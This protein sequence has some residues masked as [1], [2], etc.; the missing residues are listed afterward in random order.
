M[1][2]DCRL[3]SRFLMLGVLAVFVFGCDGDKK[4][5]GDWQISPELIC[6]GEAAKASWLLKNVTEARISPDVGALA[7]PS[8]GTYD[9][10]PTANTTYTLEARNREVPWMA[11]GG[12]RTVQVVGDTTSWYIEAQG[13]KPSPRAATC[14][15][16]TTVPD[17]DVS[18]NVRIEKLWNRTELHL[19]ITHGTRTSSVAPLGTTDYFDGDP[20]VGTWIFL[21]EDTAE[22]DKLLKTQNLDSC[23]KLR[24]SVSVGVR[25]G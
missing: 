16:K 3:L 1:R 23:E 18:T 4:P 12:T 21:P 24:L 5:Q 7:D 17:F 22:M 15:W 6:P 8:Q 19:S 10:R 2:R 25:C 11:I 14:E 13:V 20:V 9:V